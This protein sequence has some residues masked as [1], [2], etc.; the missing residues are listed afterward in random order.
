[1]NVE[2]VFFEKRCLVFVVG[3]MYKCRLH[4]P[5]IL[6]PGFQYFHITDNNF[7]LTVL[8]SEI[9]QITSLE[10]LTLGECKC[11]EYIF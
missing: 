11:L 5:I 9:G 4:D 1:M 3:K 6:N 7:D 2:T 8:P 10:T